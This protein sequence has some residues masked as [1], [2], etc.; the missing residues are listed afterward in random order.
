MGG[1]YIQGKAQEQQLQDQRDYEARMAKEARD[2]YNAN[3][4]AQ[5]WS[6]QQA[7]IYQSGTP[8]WD[9]YAEARARTAQVASAGTRPTGLAARYMNPV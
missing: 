9:P 3:V 2:R 6:P 1:A 7:P 8:A 5:L 4:G